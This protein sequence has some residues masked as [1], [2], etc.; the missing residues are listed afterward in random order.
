MITR[1]VV[2]P[3]N[4]LDSLTLLPILSQGQSRPLQGW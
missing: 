1:K 4:V 3:V 2:D